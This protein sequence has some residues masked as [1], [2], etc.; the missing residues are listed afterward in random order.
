MATPTYVAIAKTV[1]TGTTTNVTFSSISSTYTD[2]VLLISARSNNSGID[3]TELI[4]NGDSSTIY[5][6]TRVSGN[7]ATAAS[8]NLP[9]QGKA[10]VGWTDSTTET[11]NTFTSFEVYIPNY[12]STT[13]KQISSTSAYENNSTTAYITGMAN[14]YRNTSAITNILIQ[15]N[16]GNGF[17]SG[18]RFDLYGIKNS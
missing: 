17:V 11:T 3:N 2:L 5:S 13:N 7:G 9:T 10:V 14:L 6:F 12:T 15:T 16:S 8:A 1:L 18:S 4:F